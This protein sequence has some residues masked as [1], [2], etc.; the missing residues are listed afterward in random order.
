MSP[1]GAFPSIF[2]YLFI[3]YHAKHFYAFS[4]SFY[5]T[6]TAIYQSPILFGRCLNNQPSITTYTY[7]IYSNSMKVKKSK[8][9][10]SNSN[11]LKKLHGVLKNLL[12]DND[13]I[14]TK[15]E[16]NE[17]IYIK[18]KENTLIPKLTD[19]Q[20]LEKHK[21]ADENMKNVW[22]NIINKY[23]NIDDQ[24]DVIDLRTGEIVEDNGH[25]RNLNEK[26][27]GNSELKYKSI[28]KEIIDNIPQ[29][30][31]RKKCRPL[32]EIISND[33]NDSIWQDD[34]DEQH[35]GKSGNRYEELEEEEEDDNDDDEHTKLYEGIKK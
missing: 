21:K 9:N 25:I 2:M 29:N 27:T 35:F 26:E 15:T 6:G 10:S 4:F 16:P 28:M 5:S 13:K 12:K 20:V 33:E 24:G 23:E 19:D 30:N 18:S 17:V 32:Q 7:I 22:L 1:V 11:S 34:E 3:S 8:K 14:V 31:P